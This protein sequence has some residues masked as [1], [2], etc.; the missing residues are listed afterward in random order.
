MKKRVGRECGIGALE[1]LVVG[2]DDDVFLFL[3]ASPL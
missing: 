2:G 1:F 3:F